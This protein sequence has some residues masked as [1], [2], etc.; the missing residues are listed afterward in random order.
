MVYRTK[1]RY[2]YDFSASFTNGPIFY[3]TE[4]APESPPYPVLHF[5]TFFEMKNAMPCPIILRCCF[6]A[7]HDRLMI[8]KHAIQDI[9]RDN[10]ILA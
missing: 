8:F 7:K 5:M 4:F 1:G 6:H 2:N 3:T 10:V 9:E